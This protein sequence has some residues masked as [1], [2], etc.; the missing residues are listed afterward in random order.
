MNMFF[1]MIKSDPLYKDFKHEQ[2]AWLSDGRTIFDLTSSEVNSLTAIAD[3]SKGTAGAQARAILRF[4]YPSQY[5]YTDCIGKPGGTVKSAEL[6]PGKN[7][8]NHSAFTVKVK[9]NPA[10]NNVTFQ[11][12][13]PVNA[14]SARLSLYNTTG[15]VLFTKQLTSNS[16][17]LQYNC[18]HLKA[19]VYY[20]TVSTA[21]ETVSGKW[22]IVR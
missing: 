9:P 12:T 7:N 14:V 19:G 22:V 11:Y 10:H 4:A 6:K 8:E 2:A 16:H 13:L 21:S 1:T 3:S 5:S 15:K 17:K 18:S 20:Y